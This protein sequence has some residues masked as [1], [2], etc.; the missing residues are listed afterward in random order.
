MIQ[1]V[2]TAKEWGWSPTAILRH[3]TDPHKHH[4]LDY[5]F[6]LAVDTL[7]SEKCPH[8]GVPAWHAYA[9]DNSIMFKR[10][11]V[12]C[13]A[14]AHEGRESK[15]EKL[16]PGVRMVVYAVP[17]PGF[18]LPGRREFYE[19]EHAKAL[20]AAEREAAKQAE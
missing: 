9:E 18:E 6:A 4:P 16:D 5:V 17:E 2:L 7:E 10:K 3:A 11:E 20:K 12:K 19:R 1:E 15:D 13:E 8:C 14:C